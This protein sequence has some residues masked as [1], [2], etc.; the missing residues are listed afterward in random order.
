VKKFLIPLFLVCAVGAF[1][2]LTVLHSGDAGIGGVTLFTT[3]EKVFHE[4]YPNVKVD[5][6]KLDLSDGST[7]TMDAMIAAGTAPNVYIDNL[8]RGSKYMIPEYALDLSKIGGLEK[9]NEGVLAPFTRG[10]K[11]LGLPH[12]GS[13]QGMLIN[14]DVMKEIGFTVKDDWTIA[15]FLVMAEKVKQKYQGK[16][17]ATGMFAANQSGDYLING[18]FASFGVSFYKGD[19]NTSTIADTGG[20]KVYE[21]FQTL[22]KN[23]YIPPNAA[24]LN[25]DDYCL[26]WSKGNFAAT[27]FFP[28]WT[29][30][31]L[32]SAIAQ[33][34]IKEPFNFKFVPF[35]RAEGVKKVPAYYTS[36][37]T[38]VHK[39]G[40]KVDE[41]AAE[42]AKALAS[43][44]VQD[45]YVRMNSIANRS[46]VT[47]KPT[48]PRMLEVMA[49]L[50]KQG[51]QD[52]GLT[53]QRF[54]LRRATQ[55][56]ILQKVL[57]FKLTPDEAIKLYQQKLTETK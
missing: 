8:V 16:K 22:A 24:T 55:F 35:P 23:G 53:D 29:K 14:L 41:Y 49:I 32:A 51:I 4:K 15:D 48:D 44:Q 34:L 21:F 18:W 10:G 6:I 36:S 31:Y 39:T 45:L 7:L 56:P 20:A 19:Y 46:D 50:T 43:V 54:T 17:W 28:S 42:L 47:V 27:A 40:K 1:A 30:D 9:F 26:E 5:W 37:V 11:L 25:D 12:P 33:N 57:T 52:V 13:G 38:I 3:A 2:Q